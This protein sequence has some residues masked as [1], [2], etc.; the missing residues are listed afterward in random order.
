MSTLD[1]IKNVYRKLSNAFD[2]VFLPTFYVFLRGIPVPY[3]AHNLQL[4]A[5][6]SAKAEFIYNVDTQTFFPACGLTYEELRLEAKHKSLPYLSITVID[7][8]DTA[9]Y[10][11]TDFLEKCRYYSFDS[12]T[13]PPTVHHVLF[14]WSIGS[15]IVPDTSRFRLRF[16]DSLGETHTVPLI[17]LGEE[18]PVAEVES[19]TESDVSSVTTDA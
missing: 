6:G 8:I 14:A 10:D 18:V 7:D 13:T 16:I 15:Y 9:H 5:T 2:A 4:W 11:L 19:E 1:A 3:L 17:S 12:D